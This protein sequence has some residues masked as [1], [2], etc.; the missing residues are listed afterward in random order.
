MIKV[1]SQDSMQRL[2]VSSAGSKW[3]SEK[4]S[5]IVQL[6][7]IAMATDV[8]RWRKKRGGKIQLVVVY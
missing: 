8:E 2:I 4:Y 6:T 3:M 7:H 1:N 5:E